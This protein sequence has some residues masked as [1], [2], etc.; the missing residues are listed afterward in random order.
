M[1]LPDTQVRACLKAV[2][3]FL[4]KRRPRVEIRDKLDFRAD[5]N[6]S[7]VVVVE[8]RP[9]YNDPTRIIEHPVAKAKWV[10]ARKVWRLFWMRADLKWHSYSPKPEARTIS[11]V[12]SEVDRDPHGCFFG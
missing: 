2:G 6:G 10:E 8:V 4:A 3:A 1:S 12:L 7:D 9:A 5:I 11:A